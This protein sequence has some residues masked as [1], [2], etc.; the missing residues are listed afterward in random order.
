M[1]RTI[2]LAELEQAIRASWGPDTADPGEWKPDNPASCNC[3]V[4]MLVVHDYL[5]GELLSADVFRDGEKV[6]GHM[7]NRLPSG[8]EI[9]LT[10]DQ[11][12]DGETIGEPRVRAERPAPD[13]ERDLL[14]ARYEILRDR[15]RSRLVDPAI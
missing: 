4:T 6:D 7:W 15:V 9:D 14:Y 13:P 10:R 12:G 2:T 8:L 5:G 11:F 1:G 3:A